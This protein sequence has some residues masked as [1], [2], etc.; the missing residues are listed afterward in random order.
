MARGGERVEAR[1]RGMTTR[2]RE[3]GAPRIRIDTM[4]CGLHCRHSLSALFTRLGHAKEF[5]GESIHPRWWTSDDPWSLYSAG[6]STFD[7]HQ[8]GAY[9]DAFTGDL[10]DMDLGD[11]QDEPAGGTASVLRNRLYVNC[12]ARAMKW[13]SAIFD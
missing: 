4:G 9:T 5:L 1:S 7:D 3:N 2:D 8:R 13:A 10:G 11:S 12:L 6:M